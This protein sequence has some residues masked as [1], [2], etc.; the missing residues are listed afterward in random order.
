ML[1]RNMDIAEQYLIDIIYSATDVWSMAIF[2]VYTYGRTLTTSVDDVH[3]KT[4]PISTSSQR[5]LE[6]GRI[7]CR[8][9]IQNWMMPFAA[10][11]AA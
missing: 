9:V 8:A 6:K 5:I 10:Y 3:Y 4:I 2:S 11:T 1:G 7:A